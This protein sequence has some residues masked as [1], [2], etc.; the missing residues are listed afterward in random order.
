VIYGHIRD[1]PNA[2]ELPNI[3]LECFNNEIYRDIEHLSKSKNA[4]IDDPLNTYVDII[5]H[6]DYVNIFQ[7]W[8]S[9][10]KND[11][12]PT[13]IKAEYQYKYCEYL[14]SLAQ[15]NRFKSVTMPAF[16]NVMIPGKGPSH[17]IRPYFTK[18]VSE[19]QVL[20]M[21]RQQGLDSWFPNIMQELFHD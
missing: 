14:K 1:R 19:G 13:H 8:L 3:I 12:I 11:K 16:A 18:A 6:E 2:Y 7:I 10:S 5:H 15:L 4:L 20:D 21:I 9:I 17:H